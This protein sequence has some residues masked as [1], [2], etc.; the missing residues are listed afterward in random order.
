MQIQSSGYSIYGGKDIF[1]RLD[2]Y[3]NE[4][5]PKHAI[6]VLVDDNTFELCLPVV[7]DIIPRIANAEVIEI[8]SGESNKTLQNIAHIWESLTG[9][10]VDRKTLLINLGGGLVSDMGGFAAATYKRGIDFINI[11]TTLLAMVDASA[12]GKTG[13]DFNSIK[14]HIGLFSNPQ[15]VFISAE[16][17]NTLPKRELLSGYAEMLK[18]GLIADDNLWLELKAVNTNDIDEISTFI[19]KSIEIKNTVVLADPFDKT[20]R[21]KLNFGHTIGHAIESNFVGTDEELLHGEAVAIGMLCEAFIAVEKGMLSVA[22][23]KEIEEFLAE[24]YD[25][26]QLDADDEENILAYIEQDKKNSGDEILMALID[27]IGYCS[28]NIAVTEEEIKKALHY[29]KA[30]SY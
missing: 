5:Y 12:G 11:P 17:L 7:A 14:N 29:C 10:G 4:Y 3:L 30:L 13:F 24:L 18:H 21:R 25:F 20:E 9:L 2:A 15:A 8:P 22:A 27:G 28:Y 6:I 16:F 1:T 19:P 23:L 26:P